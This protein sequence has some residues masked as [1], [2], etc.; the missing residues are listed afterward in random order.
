MEKMS[1]KTKHRGPDENQIEYFNNMAIGINRLSIIG[2]DDKDA[3]VQKNFNC[4]SVLNGEITNYLELTDEKVGCDSE[5]ILPMFKKHGKD[6][7]D[8]LFGM[9]A[10]AIY[11][12]NVNEFYLYRDAIRN[13]TPILLF[14]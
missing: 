6:F 4:Y 8:K 11:D 7:I 14:K 5:I 2:P 9:F 3:M 12:C 1:F 13:K 10:I